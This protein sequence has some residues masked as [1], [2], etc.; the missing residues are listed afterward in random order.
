[1]LYALFFS[2]LI[3]A[4]LLPGS[5]EAVLIAVLVKE[6]QLLWLALAVATAGN[7]VGSMINWSLGRF[8]SH[9]RDHPRFP[10][11][12]AARE[13]AERWFERWGWAALFL[14]WVPLVGDSI[15]IVAGFLRYNPVLTAVVVA[16]AKGARYLMV[17]GAVVALT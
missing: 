13:R 16:L 11:K 3:S 15:T 2:A 9:W 17:A 1:M 4:T 8:A 12:P 10:L 14:S 5:S 6:P 7:T